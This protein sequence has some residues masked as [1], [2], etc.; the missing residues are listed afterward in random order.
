MQRLKLSIFILVI[1]Q[2]CAPGKT[3][4]EHNE[5]D[6]GNAS[7]L[8][9]NRVVEKNISSAGY[10][11]KRIDIQI[12]NENEKRSVLAALRYNSVNKD[13]LMN[14]RTNTGLELARVYAGSDTL[15]IIDR[16]SEKVFLGKP[17]YFI[18]TFGFDLKHIH[19][20]FGD[21]IS[22]TDTPG[23][24]TECNNGIAIISDTDRNS[25]VKYHINCRQSK[26]E[27]IEIDYLGEKNKL[28]LEFGKI[29]IR[30]L[31][32]H[33]GEISVT[34]NEVIGKIDFRLDNIERFDELITYP[35]LRDNYEKVQLK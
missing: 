33:A 19:M 29:K 4:M 21:C 26:A 9:L 20:L 6:T 31:F 7:V 12:V 14:I 24:I 22:N 16:F 35:V 2:G 17:E 8:Q 32:H 25:L 28:T 10:I 15:I 11:I 27:K 18:S 34:G 3:M 23:L 1:L 5:R 13:F 30:G